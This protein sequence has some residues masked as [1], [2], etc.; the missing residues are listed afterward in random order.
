MDL[1]VGLFFSC[2]FFGRVMCSTMMMALDKIKSIK[3]SIKDIQSILIHN[4]A[5][6]SASSFL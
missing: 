3:V 6:H 1:I 5:P 4:T 2:N